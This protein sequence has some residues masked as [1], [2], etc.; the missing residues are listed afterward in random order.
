MQTIPNLLAQTR[1]V[2]AEND[3]SRKTENAYLNHIRRFAD[4]FKERDLTVLTTE[5]IDEFINDLSVSA[6]YS[7]ATCNQAA[8]AISFFYREV[9]EIEWRHLQNV[10]RSRRTEKPPVIFTSDE[11][12]RILGHLQ[13]AVF[14]VAALIYGSGLRLSE[15]IALRV[16]DLDF[17]RRE[18]AVRDVRTGTKQ[19]TTIL[20]D[21]IVAALER[22]LVRVRYLFEDDVLPGFGK[23]F[24]PKIFLRKF[25]DAETDWRW[26]FLFPACKLS[27]TTGDL[28]R[29][30]IAESTVQKAI[31]EAVK[32]A[33]IKKI[34][35]SQTL[36]YSFAVRLF[37][38]QCN[39][40]QIQN[41]LGQ[42]NL[43][44]TLGSTQN[45]AFNGNFII[46]PLDG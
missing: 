24:V 13:G 44:S 37:E 39:V 31:G 46:S 35:N 10:K 18:I 8:S 1:R 40:R 26:R 25:A 14:L 30:H 34:A 42:K 32:I 28:R 16:G 20:P 17:V 2:F 45:H 3:F 12:E 43:R 9:L 23:V 5:E 4:F 19:R 15:A 38:N 33:K 11:A 7:E 36:R 22:H 27:G 41:L 29:F 6:H 21:S